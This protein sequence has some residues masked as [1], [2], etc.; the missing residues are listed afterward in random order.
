MKRHIRSGVVVL[1]AALISAS[2]LAKKYP[3]F[4]DD[5]LEKVKDKRV[6]TL[7]W[8]PGAEVSGFESIHIADFTVEFRRNWKRDQNSTRR[9]PSSR[10]TDED[11]DKIREELS[12][13]L[14]TEFTQ[15]FEEAGIPVVDDA[16]AGVLVLTPNITDLDVYAPDVSMRQSGMTSTYTEQAGRMRLNMEVNDGGSDERIGQVID[17][18]QGR[19]AQ[20]Q[21][22]NSVTNRA[23]AKRA[24]RQWAN[25]IT[26]ALKDG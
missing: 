14:V 25:V 26:D 1:L 2:A 22:T 17:L 13:E 18:K 6:D 8:K 16:G 23:D 4:T 20:F 3:D 11:M 15:A 7:Y 24:L 10:I 12:Q 9:S 19:W 21:R 5:G